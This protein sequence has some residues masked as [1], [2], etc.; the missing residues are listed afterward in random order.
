MLDFVFNAA[1]NHENSAKVVLV[2]DLKELNNQRL[3]KIA[4]KQRIDTLQKLVGSEELRNETGV[5]LK[6]YIDGT[7][8]ILYG[9]SKPT[10]R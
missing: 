5:S 6:T 4:G 10:A 3:V 7:A 1:Q 2:N 8:T 9:K